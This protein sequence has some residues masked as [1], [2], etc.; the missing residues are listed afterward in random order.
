MFYNNGY[1]QDWS[2]L[3]KLIWLRG[4][5]ATG[6]MGTDL[7][8]SGTPP[9]SL[10]NSL[11]KPLKAW[12]VDVLPYQEGSGDPSPDNVRAIHGT[13][14][15]TITTTGSNI[16]DFSLLANMGINPVAVDNGYQFS[17]N[18]VQFSTGVPVSYGTN[19][20]TVSAY[21]KCI[22][23]T[24]VRIRLALSDGT[25][26]D[27]IGTS[28]TEPT[29][30]TKT[31]YVNK[32]VVAIQFNW[33]KTGSVEVT[34]FMVNIGTDAL[35]YEPYNAS[36]T[37]LT[38][39]QTVYTGTIGSDGGE[40]RW[41]EVDL[42]TLSYTKY[43]VAQGT[44]FRAAVTGIKRLT[45][46]ADIPNILCSQ[47]ATKSN[48]TRADKSVSQQANSIEIDI[49]DSSYSDA[50]TFKTA[51][52]GVQLCYELATPTTFAVPS[53]TIPTPRGTATTWATA[54]DGTVESMEV[55][56]VGKA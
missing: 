19:Q 3:K 44:L 7:T 45:S 25:F 2:T 46:G 49:I 16:F 52:D 4:N 32:Q 30:I 13:D 11:G 22:T 33:S 37:V 36:Q 20:I 5:P 27:S 54:E 43:D 23:A 39:P 28:A 53:V 10:P 34:N 40:S 18:G 38:L 48:A 15:L 29:L 6:Q 1:N 12:S 8:V 41:G 26:Q 9:L 47:Y 17:L 21:V 50:A 14:K 31:S 55:T 56:Y 42:G 24:N 35:P 51:M